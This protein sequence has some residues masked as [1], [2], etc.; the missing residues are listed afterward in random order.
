MS[1]FRDSA[2]VLVV[3][4]G[5]QGLEVL[6]VRRSAA[7]RFF[8]GYWAL[9][10]GVLDG[11]ESFVECALR[12]LFEETGLDLAG[13]AGPDPEALRRLLIS[14]E[15]AAH[16]PRHGGDGGLIGIGS[17][18]TPAF[19][20][21]RYHTHFFAVE[22]GQEG[23][24]DVWPGELDEGEFVPVAQALAQWRE[25]RRPIVP[26]V[27]TLL[28]FLETHGW[29]GFLE[30]VPAHLERYRSGDLPPIL[31]SPGVEMLPLRTP[32]L[33]PATTTNHYL[34]GLERLYLVD[35]ATPH[36]DE[37]ERLV[38]YVRER[39]A[40][41]ARL[42]GLLLTH[43]HHDHVG[44][45]AELRAALQ[46]PVW[47]H[48][49]TIDRIGSDGAGVLPLEDGSRFDL[50]RA[51][52]GTSDWHLEAVHTPGHAPGHL[53]FQ[54]SRY[55]ALIAGDLASTAS[56]ILIEPPDGHL[57]TYLASLQRILDRGLS[58]LYPAHGPVALDGAALLR[59]YLAH[60]ASR[61]AKLIEALAEGLTTLD[62]LLPR[63]YA[64]TDPSLW[65]LARGSLAAG[66]EKLAEEGRYRPSSAS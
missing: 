60:R 59:R 44:G 4:Q 45:L 29:P 51:P 27:R 15:G 7:L 50:G 41:G 35:P 31:N 48:P 20:P 38:R 43:H 8:G 21:V 64:D 47:A 63:V 24:V 23:K 28:A 32:T 19:A 52:D 39:E 42:Q 25:G 13:G 49:A 11:R 1:G 54:E 37:Q 6:L 14:E 55:R 53:V 26:P 58:L 66:L 33:P 16:W 40:A 22:V 18:E 9:P 5:G 57:A 62:E 12:E 36:R 65:G 46:V 10:G 34:V 17:M 2:A 3:R 30:H 56:T 61:E